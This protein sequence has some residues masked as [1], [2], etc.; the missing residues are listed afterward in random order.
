MTV[1]R[2][3]KA[4]PFQP[5][6]LINTKKRVYSIS[7]NTTIGHSF[8]NVEGFLTCKINWSLS[9]GKVWS[10]HLCE[11]KIGK[12]DWTKGLSINILMKKCTNTKKYKLFT[13]NTRT[14]EYLCSRS[15]LSCPTKMN[16]KWR[17]KCKKNK[18]KI[19]PQF[20]GFH[21]TKKT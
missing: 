12:M 8:A 1:N 19:F 13:P 4:K 11:D 15:T 5:L 10:L 9:E 6:H 7:Q 21:F 17:K 2:V 20:I 16:K 18:I 14:K 3:N